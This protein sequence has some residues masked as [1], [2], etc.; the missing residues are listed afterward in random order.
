MKIWIQDHQDEIKTD[1]EK[2]K[3]WMGRILEQLGYPQGELSILLV[4]D[5]EIEDLNRRYLQRKGPTNVIAFPMREG[6]IANLNPEILGDIVV[7]IET[8]KRQ[9]FESGI[10]FKEM[11]ARLL[12]HGLLH[13]LGYDHEGPEKEAGEME[14]KEEELL[15]NLSQV[16]LNKGIDIPI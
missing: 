6:E 9:A 12:I 11:L 2:I 5:K 16:C 8:A 3:Q 14:Q 7:S 13:L 15:L 4:A 10:D 1:K